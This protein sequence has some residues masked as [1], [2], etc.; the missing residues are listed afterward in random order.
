MFERGLY[1]RA[2]AV[3]KNAATAQGIRAV[4]R[5]RRRGPQHHHV[6]RRGRPG[7]A[8]SSDWP[9]L[10]ASLNTMR[11]RIIQTNLKT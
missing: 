10:D 1:D 7:R 4:A 3:A 5:V 6:R 9:L 11:F 2:N 8:T